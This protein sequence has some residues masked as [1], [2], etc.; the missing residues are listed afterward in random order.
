MADY[1]RICV[2]MS[3]GRSGMSGWMSAMVQT[4]ARG[5][6]INSWWDECWR[7]RKWKG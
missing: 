6:E 5:R 1:Y 7:H 2:E 4:L 3:A